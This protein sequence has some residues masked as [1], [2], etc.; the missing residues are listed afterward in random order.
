MFLLSLLDTL[1]RTIGT[2]LILVL[3]YLA[4]L[5]CVI[6]GI[7]IADL[8]HK[9]AHFTWSQLVAPRG[10]AGIA[11]AKSAGAARIHFLQHNFLDHRFVLV[12]RSSL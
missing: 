6:V 8:I 10:S 4:L 12:R 9:S 2:L 3:G 7:V 11:P 5:L 1:T